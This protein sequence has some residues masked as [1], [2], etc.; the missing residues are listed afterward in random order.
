MGCQ[1]SHAAQYCTSMRLLLKVVTCGR[2]APDVH[3]S[4][5][6]PT[7]QEVITTGARKAFSHGSNHV[8]SA[9]PIPKNVCPSQEDPVSLYA[10]VKGLARRHIRHGHSPLCKRSTESTR[11]VERRLVATEVCTGWQYRHVLQEESAKP[12]PTFPSA[13][14][15]PGP[16]SRRRS[17]RI[18]ARGSC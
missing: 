6:A 5:A 9:T 2:S 18:T 3:S 16:K 8:R 7:W 15:S 13:A 10:P 4:V 14:G 1:H 12:V 11:M 17:V